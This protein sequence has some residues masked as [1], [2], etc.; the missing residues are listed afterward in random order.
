ITEILPPSVEEIT[1]PICVLRPTPEWL[2]VHAKP[3]AVNAT[4]VQNTLLWLKSHN[5]LY[6]DIKINEDCL[7]L[8]ENP[9]LPYGERTGRRYVTIVASN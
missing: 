7:Q 1:E 8:E 6:R 4:R 3:L 5:P 2:H 9:V